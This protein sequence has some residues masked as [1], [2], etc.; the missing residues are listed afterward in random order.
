MCFLKERRGSM[1][2][3]HGYEII[4]I[5]NHHHQSNQVIKLKK[6]EEREATVKLCHIYAVGYCCTADTLHNYDRFSR[7]PSNWFE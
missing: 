1:E 5:I 3:Y 6:S 4:V 7:T 2:P